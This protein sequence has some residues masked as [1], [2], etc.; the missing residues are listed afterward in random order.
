MMRTVW[1][2]AVVMHNMIV[3]DEEQQQ[4]PNEGEQAGH[5]SGDVE[6]TPLTLDELIEGVARV[7]DEG[8]Q[9]ALKADLVAHLWNFRPCD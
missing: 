9:A 8:V 1:T 5:R 7:Q 4:V 2:A 3:E 6:Q